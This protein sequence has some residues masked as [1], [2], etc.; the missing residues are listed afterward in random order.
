MNCKY[1]STQEA[2][3]I[4]EKCK[5]PICPECTIKVAD[6]TICS[7]CI[8][9]HIYNEPHTVTK[10]PF[11][12]RFLFFCYSLIPG[13]AH[14]HLGLFRRGLQLMLIP[15]GAI[16]IVEFI[17]LESLIPL[18]LIPTWFF[19]FFESHNFKKLLEKGQA[20]N[21]QDI[22]NRQLFDYTPLL[23]NHRLIGIVLT[24][25]GVLGLL[26]NI[27]SSNLFYM[28]FGDNW[29]YNN[30]YNAVRKSII[31]LFLILCGIYLIKKAKQAPSMTKDMSND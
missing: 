4:C 18:I 23:K 14:M 13:A 30:A 29:S 20:L 1:H 2:L 9:Q 11:S 28:L 5:N 21:D 31:P 27:Q 7:H 3:A 12:E 24:V 6:K 25:I 26:S 15:F 19:S 17:N 22:F 16:F 10:K 8:Q